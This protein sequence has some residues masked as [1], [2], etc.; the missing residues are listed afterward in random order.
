MII[1]LIF[2]AIMVMILV[3]INIWICPSSKKKKF[4]FLPRGAS[5]T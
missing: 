2:L 1:Y 3:G 5:P 4:I